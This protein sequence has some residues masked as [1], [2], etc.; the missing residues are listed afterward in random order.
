M[1]LN[2][3][4]DI[5][6]F[7][8][9]Q[10]KFI[11]NSRASKKITLSSMRQ[12][13][14][15]PEKTVDRSTIFGAIPCASSQGPG[16]RIVNEGNSINEILLPKSRSRLTKKDGGEYGRNGEYHLSVQH[17]VHR[18][19]QYLASHR[20]VLELVARDVL[21]DGVALVV[22]EE[23]ELVRHQLIGR[24]GNV[25]VPGEGVQEENG[26]H[27]RTETSLKLGQIVISGEKSLH[28][29]S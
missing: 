13:S 10:L 26:L 20:G 5:S 9:V 28:Y 12:A 4:R 6:R 2:V 22:L 25:H 27:L 18:V 29:T 24:G 23:T 11:Q 14:N 17:V 3:I 7:K 1:P 21:A 16:R 8:N 19:G 15:R